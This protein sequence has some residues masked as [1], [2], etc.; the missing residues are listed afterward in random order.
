MTT[1][2]YDA[3]YGCGAGSSARLHEQP[4]SALHHA[5]GHGGVQLLLRTCHAAN[6]AERYQGR[7]RISPTP[8]PGPAPG[9]S[10]T[11]T[12]SAIT[13]PWNA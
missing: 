5:S 3:I 8:G 13:A 1:A 11:V 2:S 12:A 10:G 4:L 6:V 9:E 7:D